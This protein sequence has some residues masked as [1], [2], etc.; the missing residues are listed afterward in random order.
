MDQ[1]IAE[2]EDENKKQSLTDDLTRVRVTNLGLFRNYVLKFL[3][4]SEA[5]DHNYDVMCFQKPMTEMGLPLLVR[6]FTK[7]SN[8]GMHE[9]IA[10]NT[11]EHLMA[12]ISLFDLKIY[13]KVSS[14]NL[15]SATES[16]LKE[17]LAT[18]QAAADSD[19][20][21]AK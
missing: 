19:T 5:V 21:E 2:V 1:L 18:K 20:E 11:F 15:A 7:T 16:E 12:V 6:F 8:W 4:Q 14:S 10:A 17:M 3:E 13:Q 9:T